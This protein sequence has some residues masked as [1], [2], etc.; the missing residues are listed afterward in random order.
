MDPLCTDRL[1]PPRRCA[2]PVAAPSVDCAGSHELR[3]KGF[4]DSGRRE[5]IAAVQALRSSVTRVFDCLKTGSGARGAASK[6]EKAFLGGVQEGLGAG[7]G[8]PGPQ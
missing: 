8:D 2:P 7:S 1:C 4:R 6:R 5:A 3:F